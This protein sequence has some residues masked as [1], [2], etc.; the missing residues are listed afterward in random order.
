MYRFKGRVFPHSLRYA[1]A[2]DAINHYLAQGFS[3][4]EALAQTEI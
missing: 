1:W 2:Q 4:K 3:E